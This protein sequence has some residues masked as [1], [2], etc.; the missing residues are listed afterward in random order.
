MGLPVKLKL[1]TSEM[2]ALSEI[3]DATTE[4]MQELK[5][6]KQLSKED[7]LLLAVF[8]EMNIHFAVKACR[9]QDKYQLL[10]RPQW[11]AALRIQYS[12]YIDRGCYPGILLQGICDRIEVQA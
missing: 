1:N 4:E 10:L 9:R 12:G 8:E 5:R 7:L 11:V 2:L 6:N 3:V